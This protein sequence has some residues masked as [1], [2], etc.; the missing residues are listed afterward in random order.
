MLGISEEELFDKCLGKVPEEY[1]FLKFQIKINKRLYETNIIS[2]I[3]FQEM[4]N[5]LIKKMDK[6]VKDVMVKTREKW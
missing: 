2:Y 3:I 4:N 5:L 6:V 1:V